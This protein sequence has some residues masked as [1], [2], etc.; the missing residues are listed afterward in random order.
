VSDAAENKA[1]FG[2]LEKPP[3]IRAYFR[4]PGIGRRK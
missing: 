1:I 3:E 2:G 4:R